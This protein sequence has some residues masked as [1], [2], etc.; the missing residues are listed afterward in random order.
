[1]SESSKPRS[2]LPEITASVHLRGSGTLMHPMQLAAE[3]YMQLHPGIAVTVAGS[4]TLR[5]IRAVI[6]AT[7]DVGMASS[8]IDSALQKYAKQKRVAL[9]T[10]V[11]A[12]D[13]VVPVT[14]PGISIKGLSLQQVRDIFTGEIV[15]WREI[16]GP[17]LPIVVMA[18]GFGSGTQET[19]QEMVLKEAPLT[20]KA[21]IIQGGPKI[22]VTQTPGA[23]GYVPH[24]AV[25]ASV[26]ALAVNGIRAS[27]L[28]LRDGTYPLRRSL[29]LLTRDPPSTATTG[30]ISFM[31]SANGGQ[32][33]L[34]QTGNVPVN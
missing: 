27:D 33:I 20:P 13:A 4:G 29:S 7:D 10:T 17:A 3:A 6:D 2:R 12:Y 30:F 8:A 22:R 16:G 31:L 5:G 25:D 21:I 34:A 28:T 15:N 23:I 19:W 9:R 26:N 11:I 24:T 32:A 14:H 18:Y 1:M